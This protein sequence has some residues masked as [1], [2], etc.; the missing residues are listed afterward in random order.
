MKELKK[1]CFDKQI[2]GHFTNGKKNYPTNP[3][4]ISDFIKTG[5]CV[6]INHWPYNLL[7]EFIEWYQNFEEFIQ[8]NR[9]YEIVSK[10]DYNGLLLPQNLWFDANY[11]PFI[12]H[13]EN[14]NVL[15]FTKVK[16]NFENPIYNADYFN[17]IDT[18]NT[19]KNL[20][21]LAQS[22]EHDQLFNFN[23]VFLEKLLEKDNN[24]GVFFNGNH[25]YPI[26]LPNVDDYK[27]ARLQVTKNMIFEY[28][29]NEKISTQILDNVNLVNNANNL[30]IT[31]PKIDKIVNTKIKNFIKEISEKNKEIS[32]K[33]KIISKKEIEIKKLKDQIK[34]LVMK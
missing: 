11:S 29:N 32:D 34:N 27:E 28:L 31:L 23:T 6:Y 1:Y 19:N 16:I 33:N 20:A 25:F 10:N 18:F 21:I 15:L 7:Y 3:D 4:T 5:N 22:T 24:Y 9:T 13:G 26:A 2:E 14:F 30:S 8:K 17:V 12:C